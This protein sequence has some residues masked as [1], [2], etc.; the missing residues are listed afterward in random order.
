MSEKIIARYLDKEVEIPIKNLLCVAFKIEG[1][2]YRIQREQDS[3][4]LNISTT[5][6]I[7]VHP[8]AANMIWVEEGDW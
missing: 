3:S 2:E 5:S 1:R 6:K 4:R 8:R 7:S